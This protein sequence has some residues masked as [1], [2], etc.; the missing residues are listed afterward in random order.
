MRKQ[1]VCKGSRIGVHYQEP[2][3]CR[4]PPPLVELWTDGGWAMRTERVPVIETRTVEILG[5]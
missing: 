3:K 4:N 2:L 1:L 5:V